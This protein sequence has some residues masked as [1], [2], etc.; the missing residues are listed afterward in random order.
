MYIDVQFCV[1]CV[2][3]SSSHQEERQG[4]Q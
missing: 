4:E 2:W 3:S 1:I